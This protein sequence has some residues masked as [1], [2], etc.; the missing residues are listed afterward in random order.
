MYSHLRTLPRRGRA[1]N[2]DEGE[3]K[4]AE[5][6]ALGKQTKYAYSDEKNVSE[7]GVSEKKVTHGRH[8]WRPF[9]FFGTVMKQLTQNLTMG[10]T[11]DGEIRTHGVHASE[12]KKKS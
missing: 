8:T 12:K 11:L 9:G 6:D 1:D 7:E 4:D 2:V 3:D 5:I 10:Y